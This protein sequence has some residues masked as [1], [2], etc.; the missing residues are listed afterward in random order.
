MGIAHLE[1]TSESE[2]V[3]LGVKLQGQFLSATAGRCRHLSLSTA[4]RGV[5]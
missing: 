2:P 5:V 3:R 4:S 1:V